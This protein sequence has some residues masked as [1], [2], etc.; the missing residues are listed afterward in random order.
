MNPQNAIPSV[1]PHVA[2]ASAR[3]R[4]AFTSHDLAA[5]LAAASVLAAAVIIPVTQ[6]RRAARLALCIS[7]LG[8]VDRAVLQFSDDHSNNLPGIV[9]G[10]AGELQWSYKE[11]VK[12]YLGL[13]GPSSTNDHVFACPDDRGYSDPR[14]FHQSERF[15]YGSYNFNGVVVAGAPNIAGWAVSAIREPKRTL[16]TMEWTAHG[17][18]SW[19]RSRT[20]DQNS[21][22]Y[23][24]AESVV[25]FVDGHVDFIKIYHDGHNPAYMRDP[26][27][28]Y[29][30]RYSGN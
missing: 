26:I 22:F 1:E 15:S 9:P 7:N 10:Q 13:K 30:Y 14:P 29:A 28:G 23:R 2:A 20:G 8:Q 16:L 6:S 27:A 17:P 18:L 19:H 25:A 3:H 24:D 11:Q 12:G 4:C 21:P 5:A